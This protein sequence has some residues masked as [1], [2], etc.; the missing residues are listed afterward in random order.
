[1]SETTEGDPVEDLKQINKEL[2]LYSEKLIEKHQTVVGTKTDISGSGDRLKTLE[3]FC[4]DNSIEF[5]PVSA[6]TGKGIKKLVTYL[7]RKIG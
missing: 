5:F 7:A 6:V 1:M 2:G 4:R 3:K